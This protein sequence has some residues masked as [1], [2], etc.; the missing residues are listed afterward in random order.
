MCRAITRHFFIFCACFVLATKVIAAPG[1]ILFSEDFETDLSQWSVTS[2]GGDASIGSETF[3]GGS[4][5][6]RMRW[7]TVTIT[8]TTINAAV[9]AATLEVWFRRGDDS[10]SEDPDNNEDLIIEYFDQFGAWAIIETFT[11]NGPGGE[12]F[13]RTYTIPGSALH[14][15][16]QIRFRYLQ[17]SGDDFDYWHID[18]VVITE[19]DAPAIT[20]L[21]GEWQFE[22]LFWNGTNNEVLDVSGNDLHLTAFDAATSNVAPAIAGDP[23]TCSYGV[24]NGSISFI[25]RDDDTSTA[26]SLL[27]IPN[28]LTITIWI[29]TNVI[30]TSGL[31][32]ILSKDENYEFHINSSG[33]IYWWWSWATLTTTGANL[34]I[35]QWHHVAITWR[36]GE[37]VIY[38]DGVER[39]RSARTGSLNIN[40]D[41]LQIGQDLDIPERFFDGYIDE[42]RIYENFLSAAQINQVMAETHPCIGSGVCTSSY[43]DSFTNTDYSNSDGLDAWTGNWIETEDDGSASSGRISITGGELRMTNSIGSNFDPSIEREADILGA[44]SAT[45]RVDLDTSGTLE[46]GDAFDISVSSDGG[47]NWTLLQNFTND[48]DNTYTYDVT[49]FASDLFRVRFRINQGYRS[50]NEWI[51]I[52]NVSLFATKPC[53]PDHFRV[54]HDGN[55]I[56]CLR[57]AITI[58]AE[59]ASGNLV[60]DYTGTV[61]LSLLTNNG[62]WFTDDG[63]GASTD[64]AQG[65]LTDTTNDND[66]AAT[67]QFNALDGG[68]VVLYLQNTVAETTN[69]SVAEGTTSDDDTEGDITFRPFGFTFSPDP[70][71]TQVA[72]KPFDLILTAAGQTPSDLECGV[73]EEYTGLKT[74]NFWSQYSNPVTSPTT[75]QVNATNIATNEAASL[76]QNV[77]FANGVATI[78]VQYDDVGEI[79]LSAKDE[80]DIGE[81]PGGNLDE[82]IGGITP[83]VVRP[84]GYHIA[85]D[86]EPVATDNLATVYRTAGDD[87]QITINSN[88]WQA[89]DDTDDDGI[90]DAGADLSDNGVTPN[91]VNIT[92]EIALTPV[93]QVVTQSNGCLFNN[94]ASIDTVQFNQFAAVGDAAQGTATVT[95]RWSEVGI[96]QLNALTANFMS[97]GESVSGVRNN[98][99]RFIPAS[100]QVVADPISIP[101]QCGTFTYMGYSDGVNSG[102]DKNGQTFGFSGT[103]NA[104]NRN[105]VVTQNY[106]SDF[107]YLTDLSLTAFNAT[108]NAVASGTLNRTGPNLSFSAGS[109]PYSYTDVNYQ[110]NTL[111]APFNLRIDLEAT[112]SDLVT[113]GTVNSNAFEIRLGRAR[114]VDTYGPEISNLEMPLRAE[115]FDG[116]SWVL[117]T[118]DS[119]TNYQSTNI[120]FDAGSYSDNLAAGETTILGPLTTQ[121]I[122]SGTST[123]GN[124]FWFSAPGENNYG[125]VLI[126]LDLSLQPWLQFDWNGDNSIDTSNALLSFGYYRGSDRVIYWREIEN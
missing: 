77:N 79:S 46:N 124:G 5:S 94:C 103:I 7:D 22:E 99:G 25:Q 37:Q 81:P 73:I 13:D 6:L 48:F 50:S 69:I 105:G 63:T 15:N 49:G 90:P 62:N 8:S 56:N 41:P 116:S 110:H 21:I 17:G 100:F 23:G 64:P 34:Q 54:I 68:S 43:L 14:A 10:F 89:A 33:E 24:F 59:D 20:G 76:P 84:F 3:N 108:S 120:S 96:L 98:I 82:I 97:S 28:T 115:Y 107:A 40:N 47:L 123:L 19:G 11:G 87:F 125:S 55:G 126:N 92:G 42:V 93:A 39:A 58:R 104:L 111:S 112:D 74:V 32:S 85:V 31:K 80:I 4:N 35:G 102:L 66:G 2:A 45:L 106:Q 53:G 86:G 61:N 38:V 70:V 26:D 52:D 9:S 71:S 60:T 83:F 44:V 109:S 16:L 113:S 101:L 121:S 114:L 119:C 18:D 91:I 75:V 78:T 67:Y 57:E 1:D 72:G 12:I 36:S 27:D 118:A 29:N 30:P 95:Q 65:T 117:N 122:S 51:D 88:L